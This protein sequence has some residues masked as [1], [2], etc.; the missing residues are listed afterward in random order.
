ME[1]SH[2][3]LAA[4]KAWKPHA[5]GQAQGYRFL[6]QARVFLTISGHDQID[7]G[8][9]TGDAA[10]GFDQFID[11]FFANKTGQ[12]QDAAAAAEQLKRLRGL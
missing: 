4:E 7:V 9:F 3:L 12:E 5:V 2:F 8:E 1:S 11:A 10:K 6:P